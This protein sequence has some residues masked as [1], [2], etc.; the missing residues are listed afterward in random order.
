MNKKY[1]LT[2]SIL[3]GLAFAHIAHS[4]TGG[5]SGGT[6]FNLP[7][8]QVGAVSPSWVGSASSHTS[9]GVGSKS[10]GPWT[11]DSGP[12]ILRA[13]TWVPVTFAPN[14]L[15]AL[16]QNVTNY[17]VFKD[18]WSSVNNSS[19]TKLLVAE[20]YRVYDRLLTGS[21][22]T[23]SCGNSIVL[24]PP[25]RFMNGLTYEYGA[26]VSDSA[27]QYLRFDYDLLGRN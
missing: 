14:C 9:V 1:I 18:T 21:T 27:Y 8:A 12:I 2:F 6:Q 16:T 15:S 26:G 20:D 25:H 17:L 22:V 19:T 23:P 7:K 4:Q 13:I 24:D 5:Q 10:T 3:F 11:V